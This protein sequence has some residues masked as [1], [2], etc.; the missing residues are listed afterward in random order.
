MACTSLRGRSFWLYGVLYLAVAL[1]FW[2]RQ[3]IPSDATSHLANGYYTLFSRDP[4]L[5]AVGF[6][7][8]PLPSLV[9]VP[10]LPLKALLP[11]LTQQ[12]LV[13]VLASAVFM[14][15]AVAA[16]E[17]VVKS[18]LL[19]A[20]FALNPMIIL[21]AGNGMSEASF[22][23]FLLLAVRAFDRWLATRR[24]ED[25]VPLGLAVAFAYGARYEAL[26]PVVAVPVAVA[27]V[28]YF[29]S[30]GTRPR[31]LAY[32]RLD[33][34]IAG[35]PGALAVAL[36]A[37]ASKLIV[38]QWFA[39]F[40]SEYGNS[41]QVSTNAG[42]ISSVTGDDLPGRLAYWSQ[43][44]LGLSP[45][46]LPLLAAAALL[47]WRRREWT[48]LGPFTILGSVLAFD[49]LAFLAGLS[50]GWLRFTITAIPLTTLVAG[51]L[52]AA[53]AP[54]NPVHR[55]P[56][57]GAPAFRR[58]V[59]AAGLSTALAALPG[60]L[61]VLADRDLAREETEYIT[62]SG[63]ATRRDL[64]QLD[65]RVAADLDT[66]TLPDGA[67]LA[68]AAVA[69]GVILAS[70]RPTQFVITPDRDFP[71]ALAD[72]ATARVRYLLL[73]ADAPTDAVRDTLGP[74]APTPA[75]TWTDITGKRQWTLVPT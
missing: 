70:A 51:S 52:V 53:A 65:A 74:Q 10:L 1:W 54:S 64:F 27:L 68:D 13:A 26:A 22:L 9:L 38:G 3:V 31:R 29:T 72:P 48:A 56:V 42:T 71:A 12:L 39:T 40:S 61:A 7:W 43:Q 67:V 35:F 50:F 16:L 21:Y 6:V 33:A 19:T 59:L 44:L 28:T 18:R 36:W 47:A 8:N 41:A 11:A 63:S 30:S 45:F 2:Q 62:V 23:F 17:D 46:L 49:A 15:G 69:Y 20:S 14:T 57:R 5:A 4:H 34:V 37:A 32:A 55:M 24:P 66:L 75:L 25:L 73:S 58:W 60:T